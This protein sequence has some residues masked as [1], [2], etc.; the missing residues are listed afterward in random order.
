MKTIDQ[1]KR[2]IVNV[3]MPF[4]REQL[5]LLVSHYNG[6]TEEFDKDTVKSYV[7][8]I[9]DEGRVHLQPS[10]SLGDGANIVDIFNT[11]FMVEMK[12]LF[13][14]NVDPSILWWHPM[15]K[16][17]PCNIQASW[18]TEEVELISNESEH[19]ITQAIDAPTGKTVNASD[20]CPGNSDDLEK[21]KP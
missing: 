18:D 4:T 11:G 3:P 2:Y 12:K 20:L 16:G 6:W 15:S 8:H 7:D 19:I 14:V 10:S 17:V 21:Y 1:S 13:G 9:I 5:T